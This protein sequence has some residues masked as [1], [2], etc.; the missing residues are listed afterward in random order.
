MRTIKVMQ[1]PG[2]KEP[3]FDLLLDPLNIDIDDLEYRLLEEA[4]TSV[5]LSRVW[6]IMNPRSNPVKH[7]RS[8]WE[9]ELVELSKRLGIQL[10]F[11]DEMRCSTDILARMARRKKEHIRQK[12][13]PPK[14]NRKY[15]SLPIYRS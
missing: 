7:L 11:E 9:R 8:V 12:Y 1:V 2:D 14:G 13:D 6:S 10:S 5:A 15:P 3:W 4:L